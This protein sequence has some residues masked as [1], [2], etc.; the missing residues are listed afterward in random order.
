MAADRAARPALARIVRVDSAWRPR[1]ATSR[2]T[3][4]ARSCSSNEPNAPWQS[5][6]TPILI[7]VAAALAGRRRARH[8]RDRG[9]H[10]RRARERKHEL[11]PRLDETHSCVAL[12]FRCLPHDRT[13]SSARAPAAHVVGTPH[14]WLTQSALA[15]VVP[16]EGRA[17]RPRGSRPRRRPSK[18]SQ[19]P[20]Q[21]GGRDEHDDEEDDRR[22]ACGSAGR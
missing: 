6:S 8:A 10:E 12:L 11:P 1:T 22:S 21:A 16:I 14:S 5:D 18:R 20:D 15:G 19:R 7:G 2:R 3:T 17:A 9:D 4:P 13:T